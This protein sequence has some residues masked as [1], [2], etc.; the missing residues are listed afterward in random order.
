VL[1]GAGGCG[2]GPSSVQSSQ[3][4]SEGGEKSIEGFGAEAAGPERVALLGVFH[5]YLEAIA[6]G[7][8]ATACSRLAAR[9]R[10]SLEQLV[11]GRV[12]RGGCAAILPRLLT[13]AV[14]AVGRRQAEGRVTRVRVEDDRAFV[15]FH[16]PGAKLYQLTLVR[17][18]GRWK[19]ATATASILVP[20]VSTA[21][22]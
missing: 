21:G 5:G 18:G 12:R 6:G 19:A 7:D 16:A 15:V 3:P 2:A 14:A 9:V 13:P 11:A 8:D 10:H 1:I 20:S 17:E 22:H 4:H